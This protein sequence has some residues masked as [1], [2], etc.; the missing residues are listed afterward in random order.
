M[1]FRPFL[2]AFCLALIGARDAP[3]LEIGK[4]GYLGGTLGIFM[5]DGESETRSA[6]LTRTI[7]VKTDVKGVR[8]H[9]DAWFSWY[10]RIDKLDLSITDSLSFRLNDDFQLARRYE[11]LDNDLRIDGLLHWMGPA[12]LRGQISY[13]T[14]DDRRFTSFAYDDLG[15]SL[16]LERHLDGFRRIAAGY[17]RHQVDFDFSP[18][19]SYDTQE[20]FISFYRVA[21]PRYRS[22]MVIPA[23]RGRVFI[24]RHFSDTERELL[25]DGGFGYAASVVDVPE[26][27]EPYKETVRETSAM[28]FDAEYRMR[29]VDLRTSAA[30][31]FLENRF[32][33]QTLFVL[34]EGHSFGVGGGYS[35]RDYTQQS[36][37][38]DILDYERGEGRFT[39]N[40]QRGSWQIG[41]EVEYQKTFYDL[42]SSRDFG[43]F[44]ARTSID[45]GFDTN[46]SAMLWYEMEEKRYDSSRLLYADA[47][48][49][50]A[51]LSATW[52]FRP[53]FSVT[54]TLERESRTILA[55]ENTIDSSFDLDGQ[56]IMF[57][58]RT[59]KN[60]SLNAGYR[61]EEERHPNF[62]I[63][64]RNERLTYVGTRLRL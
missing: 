33:A 6:F 11:S 47:D 1:G 34:N 42:D 17:A 21:P 48:R 59:G 23:G 4:Y 15:A 27:P 20:L 7:P 28:Y 22:R 30:R 43:Q 24:G 53:R 18:S 32:M 8:Q 13:E 16:A 55:F 37:P 50:F 19:D 5:E 38:S 26:I 3:A 35:V 46:W 60:I 31:S 39:W 40:L 57:E 49:S 64:D 62:P 63:N 58:Y 10:R 56:D 52:D 54:G 45:W 12:F 41:Q 36:L 25:K 2:I 44:N 51:V 29:D 61:Q 14:H 9:G